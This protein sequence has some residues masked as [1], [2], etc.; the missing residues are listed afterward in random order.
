MT[1]NK[2]RKSQ[3]IRN[4]QIRRDFKRLLEIIVDYRDPDYD[5]VEAIA[6]RNALY[7]DDNGAVKEFSVERRSIR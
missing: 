2:Q 4:S 1:N 5:E 6:K 3:R 7:F